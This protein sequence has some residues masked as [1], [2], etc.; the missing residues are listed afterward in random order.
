MYVCVRGVCVC[1]CECMCQCLCLCMSV[2]VCLWVTVSTCMCICLDMY[3][4]M[5]LRVCV[6]GPERAESI[7]HAGG[8]V[9]WD[10]DGFPPIALSV[11]IPPSPCSGQ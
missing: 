5:C 3:V 1:A 4:C 9:P 7:P 2:Y 8:H 11:I 6:L 10:R